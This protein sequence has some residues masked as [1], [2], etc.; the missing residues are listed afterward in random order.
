MKM[1]Q[2]K[3]KFDSVLVFLLTPNKFVYNHLVFV[4]IEIFI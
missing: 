2:G 3:V 1:K 4:R